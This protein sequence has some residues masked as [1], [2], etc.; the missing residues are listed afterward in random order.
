MPIIYLIIVLVIAVLAVVCALQNSM[1]ITI[2]FFDWIVT[3][4]LSLVFVGD[5]CNRRADRS[6]RACIVFI[7]EY[8]QNI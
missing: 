2:S 3:V 8:L 6:A 7:Q 1:L 4:S 5:A